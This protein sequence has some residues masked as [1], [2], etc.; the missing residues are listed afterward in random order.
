MK[1][2]KHF[3][4]R[5]YALLI[6][7][8]KEIL[9]AEEYHYSTFMRKFPGGGLQFGESTTDCLRRE[10]REELGIEIGNIEHHHTTDIFVQSAFNSNHQVIGIYYAT[11]APDNL[12]NK[13]RENYA[14]P[15][16]EGEERFRW[17]ALD[18]IS[19]ND[20]TFPID[21]QAMEI[22]LNKIKNQSF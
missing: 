18:K 5:V 10:L 3:N 11:V 13:Y 14:Q 6:N 15:S 8:K 1:D 2:D 9:I 7:I 21:K 20:F 12:I 22:F 19:V 4:I 16:T 17:I